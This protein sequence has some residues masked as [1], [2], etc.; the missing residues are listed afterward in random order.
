[1]IN[2]VP[3]LEGYNLYQVDP[4]L[5]E[6]SLPPAA[7]ERVSEFGARLGTPELQRA[8]HLANIYPPVLQTHDRYGHRSDT[9]DFHPSY[10]QLMTAG[11]GFGVH[12]LPW[13]KEVPDVTAHLERAAGHLML[14]QVEAGVGC[15]LTMTFAGVP[16]LLN[17]APEE[18]KTTWIP[19]LT[20]REYDQRFLPVTEKT[21]ATMGMAMTEKQGGS[22]VR[23]NTTTAN[24]LEG[25][26]YSLR[27][28]KWFC[29]APMSDAF[30]TLAQTEAGLTCFFVPRFRPD[31]TVN[32][33]RVV[34]LKNKLG[35]K[36]NASSEI[37]YE[38]TWAV[39]VGEEGR[40][41]P[42]I[43]EMVNHTRL[44][45]VIGSTALMRAA[46]TQALHHV[47]HRK[48]FGALL[49]DQ[50]LMI[51]V[52]ADLCL[53]VEAAW[54]MVVRLCQAYGKAAED[55]NERA[56]ARIATA[57]AKFWVCKRTP[58]MVVECLE[59]LGGNGYTEDFPLAR[60]FRESPLLSVWE[61]SGNVISLDL[62]RSLHKEPE[63]LKV[64]LA[65]LGQSE[66]AT[67]QTLEAMLM[68][69]ANPFAARRFGQVLATRWQLQLLE[70]KSSP[71]VA[72][73]YHDTRIEHGAAIF[74]LQT[75]PQVAQQILERFLSPFEGTYTK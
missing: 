22:D 62:L 13:T 20:A 8:G 24:R 47:R 38:D 16:A 46:L 59:C 44:D 19:K 50:P 27:G 74:G 36:A 7:K 5:Q 58:S 32:N 11:M 3:P 4:L 55:P 64:F 72:K 9:V 34:R 25:D 56:F 17:A 68:A 37:E 61:G 70:S 45:C 15:P 51:N 35:N 39:R 28:H 73:A 21:A 18:L 42:T 26:E 23:A 2:Q 49:K 30:L 57:V 33:L 60:L 71:A 41:V 54:R 65:E 31:G 75:K 69:Q 63:S 10:H 12:C 29:S 14:S 40:G 43:I 1:M 48:A 67:R 6:L 52:L 66:Y 53:E